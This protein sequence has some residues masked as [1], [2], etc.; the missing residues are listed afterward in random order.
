MVLCRTPFQAVIIRHVLKHERV[1]CYD[2]VYFTHDNAEEDIHYFNELSATAD[3][4]QYLFIE[5][6]RFDILNHIKV[7][8]LL[9][10]QIKKKNYTK[11]LISSFDS[12]AFRKIAV[13]NKGAEVISFDDGIGH[14]VQDSAYL[15]DKSSVRIRTYEL[16]FGVPPK[17][18][19]IGGIA[20]HYSVYR[21]FENIM[22]KNIIRYID[23]FD[24]PKRHLTNKN[25]IKIFI[26]Q[27]FDESQDP[28]FISNLRRYLKQNHFDFYVKHPMESVPLLASIPMLSKEGRIAEEAILN[29]CGESRPLIVGCF[30]SVF[31]NIST[32]FAEKVIIF[33]R[34]NSEKYKYY[35]ELGKKADC[36]IIY[37]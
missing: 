22:P 12:L 1:D 37:I 19:F 2:L 16:A 3:Q 31:F 35:A 5:R 24:F 8:R 18:E 21:D 25:Q 23:L 4:A 29:S 26:G 33:S 14:I 6:Q 20:R 9:K 30:S 11:V 34:R 28:I 27:P 13:K 32:D 17:K 7:Y 10:R 15:V 36:R